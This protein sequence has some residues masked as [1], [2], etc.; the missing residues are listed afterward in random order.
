MTE[1]VVSGQELLMDSILTE[2]EAM[3]NYDRVTES[4]KYQ[5]AFINF[6]NGNKILI[7]AS[8]LEE[9]GRNNQARL[10]FD[11]TQAK[12]KAEMDKAAKD[13]EK[14]KLALDKKRL[15]FENDIQ[16]SKLDL[17]ERRIELEHEDS[18]KKSEVDRL[19]KEI[20]MQRL[21]IEADRLDHE[22]IMEQNRASEAK[23]RK[24]FDIASIAIEVLGLVSSL[25]LTRLTLRV[26]LDSILTDKDAVS[27]A[28][29]LFEHFRNRK[30]K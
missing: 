27:S 2:S 20:E 13:L 24:Y 23:F 18:I 30:L 16:E 22:R 21:K 25:Y 11:E 8:K 14:K 6:L 29:K 17:E 4:E 12:M 19:L 3:S 26:N 28:N 1:E 15:E 7:E 10:E 5:K 9:A